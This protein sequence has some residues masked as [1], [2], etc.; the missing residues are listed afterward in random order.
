[1]SALVERDIQLARR[2]I[3]AEHLLNRAEVET[4]ELCL[5]ILVKRQPVASD[6]RFVYEDRGGGL[7]SPRAAR[8][9]SQMVNERVEG[10]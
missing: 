4:D 8:A 10:R 3:D 7:S 6:L 2:T 9:L 1:M 5:V